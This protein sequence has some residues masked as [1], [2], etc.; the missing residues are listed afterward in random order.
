MKFPRSSGILLHPTSLP[1]RYGIG[2][3]GHEAYAFVD[4]LVNSGQSLWQV[5]PLGPTG[6]GDSPYQCFSAFAGNTL[7]ISPQLLVED[8]LLASHDIA[9]ANF[10]SD[11]VDFGAVITFKHD[12]LRQAFTRFKKEAPASQHRMEL[13]AFAQREAYWLDDYALYR[14]LKDDHGGASWNKWSLEY[15]RRDAQAL[16]N[17]RKRLAEA[18]EEQKFLQYLFSNSGR[19]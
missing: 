18:I 4:F 15:V 17:A 5:L 11:K 16:S 9:A 2:D 1:G 10:P 13:D 7:L 6:Y 3:L 8:Q 19:R 12:C 14:A